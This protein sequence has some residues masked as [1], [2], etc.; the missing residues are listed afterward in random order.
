MFH[1]MIF[2]KSW[3]DSEMCFRVISYTVGEQTDEVTFP[4]FQSVC[5]LA[6]SLLAICCLRPRVQ[7]L[8][9]AEEDTLSPFDLNIACLCQSIDIYNNK[10]VYRQSH[11]RKST[12]SGVKWDEC[13]L[14]IGTGC[15][16]QVFAWSSIAQSVCQRTFSLLAIWYLRP[17]VLFLQSAEEDNMSPFDLNIACLYQSIE[18]NNY[19]HACMYVCMYAWMDGC[20]YIWMAGCMYGYSSANKIFA[21]LRRNRSDPLSRAMGC[22]GELR[23]GSRSAGYERFGTGNLA[24]LAVLVP[25]PKPATH[26]KGVSNQHPHCT[27]NIWMYHVGSHWMAVKIY[28]GQQVNSQISVS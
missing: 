14:I 1:K 28:T 4:K 19:K 12:D 22:I 18:I 8:H 17:Q 26:S 3:R 7:I 27:V 25:I 13:S 15:R 2:V 24:P 9:S 5:Q 21:V 16:V 20:M 23:A 11:V 10:H 6:F